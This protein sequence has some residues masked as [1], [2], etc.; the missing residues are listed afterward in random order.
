MKKFRFKKKNFY[1]DR[2]EEEKTKIKES[3]ETYSTSNY[4]KYE[5]FKYLNKKIE[6][7]NF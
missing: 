5:Y 3:S 4:N 1:S 2:P 7:K 6:K